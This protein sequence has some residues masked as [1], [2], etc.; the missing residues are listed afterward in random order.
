VETAPAW[1][2]D[3]RK[4]KSDVY[5]DP[6][7]DI[8]YT[9][10][11]RSRLMM[12]AAQSVCAVCHNEAF[13]PGP[14]DTTSSTLVLVYL[15]RHTVHASCAL[16]NDDIELPS[17]QDNQSVNHLLGSGDKI[18]S[19]RRELGSKLSFAASVRVRVGKCP[20]CKQGK[21][22]NDTA[23]QIG[24]KQQGLLQPGRG[25]AVAA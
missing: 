12:F 24:S 18:K 5:K 1:R 21:G 9:E 15:C 16:L 17:R 4:G 13:K 19:R 7:S 23:G 11:L 2:P 20:V 14:S 10:T 22:D 8:R 6:V 25:V 3:C